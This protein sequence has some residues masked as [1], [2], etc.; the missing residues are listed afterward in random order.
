MAERLI[1]FPEIVS[2]PLADNIAAGGQFCMAINSVT[3]KNRATTKIA[4]SIYRKYNGKKQ[5]SA[6][7]VR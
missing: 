4:L 1:L 5:Q 6:N 3:K 7:F 2:R